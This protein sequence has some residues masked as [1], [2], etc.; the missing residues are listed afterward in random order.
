MTY[1]VTHRGSSDDLSPYPLDE[2]KDLESALAHA[3]RLLSEGCIEVAIQDGNGKQ[4]SGDDLAACCRGE[5]KL[6]PDLFIKP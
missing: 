2:V 5:K 4:V 1:F 3:C 6:M